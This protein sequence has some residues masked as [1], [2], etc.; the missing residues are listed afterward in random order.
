MKLKVLITVLTS[1]V[2]T[3]ILATQQTNRKLSAAEKKARG[4]AFIA[5]MGG[6]VESI[7]TGNVIRVVNAQTI[8]DRGLVERFANEFRKWYRTTPLVSDAEIAHADALKIVKDTF[9]LPRTGAVI[10]LVDNTTLPTLLIAPEEGYAIVNIKP[11]LSDSPE[12]NKFEKRVRKELWRGITMALGA[13]NSHM[14]PCLLVQVRKPADLDTVSSSIPGPEPFQ[15]VSSNL[16]NFGL[17]LPKRALYL[18]ACQEGWAPAPTNEVQK[19]IWERAKADKERGPSNPIE[20]PMP[21]KK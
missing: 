2:A 7:P 10:V 3:N 14:V 6:I 21:K 13:T 12:K 9:K 19:A 11:L 8:V 1:I 15:K 17:T 16:S 20:I 5:E 4:D 18:T